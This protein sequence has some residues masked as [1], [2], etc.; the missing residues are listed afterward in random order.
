MDITSPL[1]LSMGIRD[2]EVLGWIQTKAPL[3]LA[4]GMKP[5]R[6][7]R[8]ETQKRQVVRAAR[9]GRDRGVVNRADF[10]HSVR[11]VAVRGHDN[12]VLRDADVV[13][14]D[15]EERD[16][17]TL[18]RRTVRRGRRADALLTLLKY[19]S[20]TERQFAA[21]ESLR[22]DMEATVAR[23]GGSSDVL[24]LAPWE[25]GGV[26]GRQIQACAKVRDALAGIEPRDHLTVAWM[27]GGGTVTGMAVYA[28]VS[29]VWVTASLRRALD[30]LV[31]FYDIEETTAA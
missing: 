22:A 26:N 19:K 9:V 4:I 27:L 24:H 6:D 16:E 17:G 18:Q 8:S 2:R 23:S 10:G 5:I 21:A 20:I 30:A 1:L 7:V 14:V 11:L 31:A 15:E 3:L 13:V 28:R 12:T 29:D 25:R